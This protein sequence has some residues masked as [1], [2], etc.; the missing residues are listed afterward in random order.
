MPLEERE[1]LK[2]SVISALIYPA[3]LVLVWGIES[4]PR[5]GLRR[6][7]LTAA[8]ALA[9]GQYVAVTRLGL[10]TPCFLDRSLRWADILEHMRASA[11]GPRHGLGSADRRRLH[12]KYEQ[13]VALEGFP[14][15]EALA[16]AWQTFPGVACDLDT[17]R[18]PAR[19]SASR[20]L[21]AVARQRWHYC[22]LVCC[23]P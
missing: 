12:W 23:Q 9:A 3:V 15:N 16:L 19:I 7:A 14:P 17:L 20:G 6:A 11:P 10:D 18:D 5:R 1:E 21:M 22:Y 13:N 2:E 8:L 4:L